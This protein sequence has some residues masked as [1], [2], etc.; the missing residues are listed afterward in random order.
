VATPTATVGIR[1]TGGLI[2]VLNDGA[3]LVQGTS[4]IWF[5]ANPAGSIDIPAGVA[6]IAPVDPKQ[7]PKE[8]VQIPTAGPSPLPLL[9]EYVQGEQRTESGENVLSLGLTSGPGYTATLA[10]GR[11]TTRA[12]ASF[13]NS[14]GTAI[15]NSSGQMTQFEPTQQQQQL[16]VTELVVAQILPTSTSLTLE[17]GSRH[18]EFGTDGILAWGRW[19][20]NV[21]FFGTLETYSSNTGLHYVVGM[22]TPSMPQS[23][24]ATYA[25]IGATSP[26]EIN[27]S[28]TPGTLT[29][30]MSVSD[31]SAGVI[32]MNL[33]VS[34][35]SA[36]LGYIINGDAVI[37]GSSFSGSFVNGEGINGTNQISC[38]SGCSAGVE[39]FFAG[40]AATRAGLSY[41]IND[42]SSIDIV[43]A[44]AFAKQ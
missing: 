29:G 22:P 11:G 42:N 24:Q 14:T 9:L 13:G 18:A 31:W 44:A 37:S 6:G 5:L 3:T 10:F 16:A 32:T 41:H 2:Q 27:G 15:F 34:M 4:G 43:G 40:D 19:I 23:G 20:D 26:T 30:S 28:M 36:G 17:E 8:T 25:L 33:N 35:P 39:G 12:T 38:A 1:G 7:P 21:N